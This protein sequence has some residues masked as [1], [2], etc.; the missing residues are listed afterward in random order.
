MAWYVESARWIQPCPTPT[1]AGDKPPRY[2]FSLRQR[3]SISDSGRLA[4]GEPGIEVEWRAHS[5]DNGCER[6]I[7]LRLN[8]NAQRT[9]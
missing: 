9:T 4:G 7:L 5:S 3:P 6:L 8:N 1:P 2:I